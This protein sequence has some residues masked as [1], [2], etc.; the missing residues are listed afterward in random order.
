[1]QHC[2]FSVRYF[3]QFEW[4][5]ELLR[6]KPSLSV[7]DSKGQRA[8]DVA[9]IDYLDESLHHY[10]L[11]RNE[12]INNCRQDALLRLLD[13]GGTFISHIHK[14]FLKAASYGHFR[15][16]LTLVQKGADVNITDRVGRTVLHLCW[17]NYKCMYIVLCKSYSIL[18]FV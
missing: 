17:D 6:Y 10:I 1:M 13:A 8:V 5:D 18:H 7:A 15:L 2:L 14:V 9:L 3:S 4:L 12:R 16:M 11:E